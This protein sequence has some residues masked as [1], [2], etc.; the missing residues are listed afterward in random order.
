MKARNVLLVMSYSSGL[1]LLARPGVAADPAM[2]PAETLF[3]DGVSLMEKGQFGNACPKLE[4]SL[5]IERKAGT[6]F[7]LADCEDQR[8]RIAT[9]VKWYDE[10]LD[11]YE[12]LPDEKKSSHADRMKTAREQKEKL[13]LVVPKLMLVM[14]PAAPTAVMV[15]LDGQPMSTTSLGEP[16]VLDPGEHVI[17]TQVPGSPASESRV[18]LE[19]G[20]TQ[21]VPLVVQVVPEKPKPPRA[22]KADALP[23]AA[24]DASTKSSGQRIGGFVAGGIGAAGFLVGAIAGGMAIS[25]KGTM[26]QDCTAAAG[27]VMK[28]QSQ[29]GVDAGNRARTLANVSTAG[30]VLGAVGLTVGAVL[31]VLDGRKASPS[32]EAPKPALT[33]RVGVDASGV[34]LS[35][36]GAW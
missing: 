5:K 12:Q 19:R 7:A 25:A 10:Y 16:I 26:E 13:A 35:L 4:E 34:G 33:A 20:Q 31:V 6:L 8:G 36:Q 27:G 11:A 14:P 24:E 29:A 15:K 1:F 2:S 17:V 21:R 23:I 28:C 18:T 30:I 22:T 3:V 32:R 9:A